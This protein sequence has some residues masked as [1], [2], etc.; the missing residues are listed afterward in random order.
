MA[1]KLLGVAF[2]GSVGKRQVFQPDD[3]PAGEKVK[4]SYVRTGQRET[5]LRVKKVGRTW[6]PYNL[7][8]LYAE[9]SFFPPDEPGRIV[10][11]YG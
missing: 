8:P 4:R 9:T 2:W 11:T 1:K 10:G 7:K 6:L 3:Q 5:A